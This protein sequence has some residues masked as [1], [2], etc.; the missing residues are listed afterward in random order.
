[1]NTSTRSAIAL[2]LNNKPSGLKLRDNCTV[3]STNESNYSASETQPS[4]IRYFTHAHKLQ[5]C[6][7]LFTFAMNSV[8]E[9]KQSQVQGEAR[10]GFHGE[11]RTHTRG[12]VDGLCMDLEPGMVR[13]H[14]IDLIRPE[15]ACSGLSQQLV[16][17]QVCS[18]ATKETYKS[19]NL[20]QEAA[21]SFLLWRGHD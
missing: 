14:C 15:P 18:A 12:L 13:Q 16:K 4:Y 3:Y 2:P 17:V 11:C 5:F 20:V 21:Q 19:K 7:L 8:T 10:S 9:T 6:S 1:M